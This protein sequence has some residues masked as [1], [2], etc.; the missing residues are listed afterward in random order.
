MGGGGGLVTL[1]HHS[2]AFIELPSP[3]NYNTEC[4]L[5]KVQVNNE[6]LVIANMYI[7]P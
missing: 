6:D 2:I 1:V 3:F 4:L 5:V 7:P